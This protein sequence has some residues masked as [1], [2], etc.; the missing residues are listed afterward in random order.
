LPRR[1]RRTCCRSVHS[2]GMAHPRR[3]EIAPATPTSEAEDAIV[4]ET[5]RRRYPG[6]PEGWWDQPFLPPTPF[7]AEHRRDIAAELVA[8][9]ERRGRDP[10]EADSLLVTL[11]RLVESWRHDRRASWNRVR[12]LAHDLRTAVWDGHT[13]IAGLM[14]A[15]PA[16]WKVFFTVLDSLGS[17]N[18]RRG[19]VATWRDT[20]RRGV[21]DAVVYVLQD[22]RLP[23]GPNSPGARR[24]L[25]TAL[26]DVTGVRCWSKSAT[27][28]AL[29]RAVARVNRGRRGK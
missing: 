26:L 4:I 17:G 24:V 11:E 19:R 13:T 16:D 28:S 9:L 25:E 20:V 8:M 7:K 23:C 14:I 18:V 29:K 12:A 15:T 22:A 21:E 2:A 10:D 27:I 6:R 3:A 5:L 1:R